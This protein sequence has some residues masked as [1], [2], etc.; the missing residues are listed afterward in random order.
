MVLRKMNRSIIARSDIYK[1]T[2]YNQYPPE[3]SEI[4]SYFESRN[5][6]EFPESTFF[7]LQYY[8]KEYLSRPFTLSDVMQA[9]RRCANLFGNTRLFNKEGWLYILEKY[10]GYLPVSIKAV[11]EGLTVP[12]SN[13]LMTIRNTDKKCY[14]LPNFLE[15]M[16]VKVWAP[17]TVCTVS[18]EAKKL[19]LKA[20]DKSGDPSLI[21][22]KLHDFGYRGVSSEETA[23]ING[24]AHLVNFKGTDTFIALEG[25]EEY[26]HEPSAGFSIPASE[27]STM[28][29]WGQ[30][31]EMEAY[32]NMLKQFPDGYVAIVSDSWDIYNAVS[33]IWGRDPMKREI[34]LR[35]GKVICR[36]DSGKPEFVVPELFQRLSQR[37]GHT[38]NDKGFKVLNPHVGLI[39]G[40][41]MNLVSMGNLLDAVMSHGWSV[42]DLATG[43]GG[44]LLQMNSRDTLDVAFKCSHAINLFGSMDVFKHPA[45]DPMKN[46]KKGYLKLINQP[47]GITTISSATSS[48]D[49]FDNA[50]DLLVEVFRDGKILKEWTLTEIRERAKL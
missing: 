16:L 40:D 19:W 11:P 30:D 46:S 42:N 36:P 50:D 20:L 4:Y 24:M 9:E 39:Q 7:G 14:W 34:L 13:V 35:T 49:W 12:K 15:T 2:Q 17:T 25:A 37:F 21:D 5:K 31:R 32:L 38:T 43:M 47:H 26:Y 48:S 29:S 3:T 27:H 6:S 1:Y 33:E 44:A 45:T 22:F 23:M 10:N 41:G 28:T 18:R 8:L